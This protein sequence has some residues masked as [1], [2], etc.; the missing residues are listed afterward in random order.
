VHKV[1]RGGAFMANWKGEKK[2]GE[3]KKWEK[4]ERRAVIITLNLIRSRRQH[5]RRMVGQ[6]VIGSAGGR[7]RKDKSKRKEISNPKG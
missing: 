6:A 7:E 3:G 2:V 5:F 4:R 1:R